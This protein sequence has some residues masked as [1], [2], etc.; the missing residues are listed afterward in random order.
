MPANRTFDF[1]VSTLI[2]DSKRLHA[3]LVDTTTGP[4]V[5]RRLAKKNTVAG[6][7]DIVFAPL[8]E[9]QIQLVENGGI[10]QSTAVGEI[11]QMTQEQFD[12]FTELERLL[13]GAR[14]SAHLAF[15]NN[16]ARL[17]SEFQVG[18]H[19]PSDFPSEI[20]RAKKVL[21]A[22]Q[23]HADAL[24]DHG[25]LDED[26]AALA[27]SIEFLDDGDTTHEATKDKKK[28]FTKGRNLAANALYKKCQSVQNAARLAYPS[29]KAAKDE[30]TLVARNRFLLDEFPP[31]AGASAGD[32]PA[33]TPTAP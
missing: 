32:K 27:A 22:C 5:A 31:R 10:A 18:I 30:A 17:H 25:W 23:T 6:Q 21:A 4:A 26:T 29:T 7:P 8:F 11:G 1:P 9:A 2:R 13:S 14:R 16:D 20:E 24:D 15:P 28:G 12:A 33:P 3:A 19:E